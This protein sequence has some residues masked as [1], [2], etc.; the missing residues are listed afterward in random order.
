MNHNP[1]YLL[2]HLSCRVPWHDNGWNGTVCKNPAANGAC[3]ILK[4][5]ALERDD[6]KEQKLAGHSLEG[7]EEEDFPVCVG[8]RATFMTCFPFYRT[9][10][11]PYAAISKATHGRLKDTRVRYPA[12]AVAAVPY[13][14]MLKENAKEKVSL[15]DLDYDPDR[16]PELAWKDSWVQ[17]IHNQR[18]LLDCFFEHFE[19][20]T[21]LVFFYAKQVPF[22]EDSS[23]VLI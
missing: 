21:S 11:H 20:K 18:A 8:E 15:Y 17:E 3:L 14:W 7:L 19:E 2:R 5:C 1:R 13:Y 6:Q 16:E 9:L 23:R 22:I 12:Y 4:N 10:R